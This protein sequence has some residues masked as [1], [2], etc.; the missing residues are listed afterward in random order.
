MSAF[1][2][3]LAH[4]FLAFSLIPTEYGEILQYLSVFSPNVGKCRENSDQNNSE[5]GHFL[6][7]VKMFKISKN[8]KIML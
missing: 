1:G 8:Y 7:S 2:V 5:F 6:S 4:I 3:I